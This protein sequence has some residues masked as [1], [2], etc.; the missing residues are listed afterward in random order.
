MGIVRDLSSGA[1]PRYLEWLRQNRHG[2]M[3]YLEKHLEARKSTALILEGCQSVVVVA[4]PY[5]SADATRLNP[6]VAQY[7]QFQ[8]YHRLIRERGAEIGQKIIDDLGGSTDRF[9]V[10]VDTAPVLERAMAEQTQW[11]F[12]GKNTCLIH[13]KWGSFLLLGEIFLTVELKADQSLPISL[14]EKSASGGCGPCNLCQIECPT[15]ALD[16]D[17]RIDARKCL[18]YWTIENRGPVPVEF[19]RHFKKYWYGCDLCQS[20]CPYNKNSKARPKFIPTKRIPKLPDVVRMTQ[21]DYERYFG[22]TPM[23]R[24]KKSGLRRNA[25]IAMVAGRHPELE[26]AIESIKED[27]EYPLQETLSQIPEFLVLNQS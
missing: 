25:L 14:H 1:Y 27:L 12:I 8:D 23:T 18:A 13:P 17:Y 4:L 11:G 19:W 22:G 15:S 10:C 26:A 6:G 16:E 24:A 2:G 21:S 5:F 9:R 7:A 3:L 20:S